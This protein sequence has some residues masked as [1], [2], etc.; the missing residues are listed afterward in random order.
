[1]A[2]KP[3]S[4]GNDRVDAAVLAT[5]KV[6]EF[7]RRRQFLPYTMD[8]TEPTCGGDCSPAHSTGE[9]WWLFI[10]SGNPWYTGSRMKVMS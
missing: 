4:G 1:M 9:Q 5:E 6:P 2:L 10:R 8:V 3:D 7:A